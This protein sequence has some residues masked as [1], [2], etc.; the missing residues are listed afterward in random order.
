MDEQFNDLQRLLRLKRYEAPPPDYFED[1]LTEFHRRQRAELLRRPLW[2]LAL[3]R[4]EGALPTFSPARYAYAGACAAAVAATVLASTHILTSGPAG[5]TM[6]AANTSAAA[7]VDETY[8]APLSGRTVAANP[9]RINILTSRPSLRLS[10]EL[11]FNRPR[12]AAVSYASSRPRYV[13]DTQPVSYEK[14][15]SF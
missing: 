6:V 9:P 14:P 7:A 11:D 12:P 1:F 10:P 15:Y 2:R 4:L 3:D 8:H 5:G 13:L